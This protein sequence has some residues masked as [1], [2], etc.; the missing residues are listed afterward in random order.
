[1]RSFHSLQKTLRKGTNIFFYETLRP[2]EYTCESDLLRAESRTVT[3]FT[4]EIFRHSES[5][6]Q[7]EDDLYFQMELEPGTSTPSSLSSGLRDDR[8]GSSVGPILE[9]PKYLRIC[10]NLEMKNL[11]IKSHSLKNILN[12]SNFPGIFYF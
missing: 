11:Y 10:S 2:S 3:L 4:M 5:P 12:P 9:R 7:L 8:R 6:L 1:M